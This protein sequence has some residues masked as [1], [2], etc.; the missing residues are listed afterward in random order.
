MVWTGHLLKHGLVASYNRL[1]ALF[2]G[3]GQPSTSRKS[4]HNI[5]CFI[6]SLVNDL[7]TS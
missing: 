4:H 5:F 3:L 1:L 6:S 7:V 2:Y